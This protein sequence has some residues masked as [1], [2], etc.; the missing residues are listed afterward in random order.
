MK[1]I[2]ITGAGSGLGR[3]LALNYA[4][5]GC[6]IC[7]AD[8]DTRAGNETVDLIEAAY[9]NAFFVECDIASQDSVK[10]LATALSDQWQSLD[11]LINNAGVATAGSAESESMEQ[12]QWAIDIN[13]LGQVRVTQAMLPLLRRSNAY[14]RS[15]IN[16]ASQAAITPIGQMG[17]YSV[18]KAGLVAFAE[19]LHFELAPEKIHVSVAC[20]AFFATNLHHSLRTDQAHMRTLVNKLV[21]GSAVSA[22]EV[23]SYIIAAN[24]ALEFM[25]VTHKDGRWAYRMK[26]FLPNRWYLQNV[27]K[28]LA[29]YVK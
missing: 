22:D 3:A 17:S 20:P 23:A 15:I 24:A 28:H 8:R 11:G 25:I 2:L 16:I 29:K 26:R 18:S 12:W 21:G 4:A 27:K 6:E 9:G 14:N 5:Q 19:G 13:L 7:V 10:R 1:N